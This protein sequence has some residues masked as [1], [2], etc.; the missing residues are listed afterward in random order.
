MISI[1][2][3]VIYGHY[4]LYY[5]FNIKMPH[6]RK[7]SNGSG[8]LPRKNFNVTKS[9]IILQVVRKFQENIIDY[10]KNLENLNKIGKKLDK[11]PDEYIYDEFAELRRL[12]QL[13]TEELIAN[14]KQSYKKK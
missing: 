13:E 6:K 3:F 11:N 10:N 12:I 14:I 7:L 1:Y 5:F 9:D 8:D 4:N 2:I